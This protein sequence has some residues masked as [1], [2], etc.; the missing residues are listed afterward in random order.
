MMQP[1]LLNTAV[2]IIAVISSRNFEHLDF[3]ITRLAFC[4]FRFGLQA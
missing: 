4:G 3:D 2:G 1:E